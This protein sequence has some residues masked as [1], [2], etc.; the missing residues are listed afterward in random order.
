MIQPRPV[1]F[2]RFILGVIFFLCLFTYQDFYDITQRFAIVLS[3]SGTWIGLF[4][5]LTLFAI[6]VLGLLVLMNKEIDILVLTALLTIAGYSLTDTVVVFDRIRE[7]MKHILKIPF[8]DLVNK[9]INEVLSRTII[10]SM[11][12]FFVALSL[13][14]FGGDVINTFAFVLLIGIVVGTYSSIYIASPIALAMSNWMER[15]KLARRSRR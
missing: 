1:T 8:I 15:R 12:T 9:S 13:F 7:N 2:W 5:L 6:S 11:T 14:L 4:S 3:T 10:T